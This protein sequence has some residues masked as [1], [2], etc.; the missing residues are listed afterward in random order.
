[1]ASV[2]NEVLKAIGTALDVSAVTSIA[3]GG[4]YQGSADESTD[5]PFVVFKPQAFAPNSYTFSF[6]QTL[7]SGLILVQAMSDENSVTAGTAP[8]DVN[9]SI[10]EQCDTALHA[11]LSLD[12]HSLEYLRKENDVPTF[13]ETGENPNRVISGRLYMWKAEKA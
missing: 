2:I 6:G 11:T 12:T 4:V 7:E 9:D 1:M 8:E 10:L 13:E 5:P 3:T